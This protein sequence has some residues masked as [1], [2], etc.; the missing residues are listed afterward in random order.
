MGQVAAELADLVYV[1]DD[2]PRTENAAAIRAEIMEGCPG[3]T[4]IGDRASAIEAAAGAAAP[5]DMIIVAGK[6]HETGQIL[7]DNT[8][9]YSDIETVRAITGSGSL[10]AAGKG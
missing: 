9:E 1:T 8:I 10:S 5:G 4:E 6:G 2:N 7:A 3:A